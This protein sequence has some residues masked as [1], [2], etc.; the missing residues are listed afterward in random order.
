MRRA[1]PALFLLLT[2]FSSCWATTRE[3]LPNGLR[4]LILPSSSTEVMAATMLFALPV[5]M[6]G[7]EQQGLRALTHRLLL[8]GTSRETG[9]EMGSRL[10]AVGG[11]VDVTCAL[12]YEEI[13]VQAPSE[14]FG[15]AL[16]LL[17]EAVQEPAFAPKEVER[18]KARLR[19]DL[20][21]TRE[22]PFQC[23]YQA[24]REELYGDAG[25]GRW[26]LG[27]ASCLSRLTPGDV[28]AFY[29]AH[30]GPKTAVLAIAGGVEA[31]TALKAVQQRFGTWSGPAETKAPAPAE[32]APL[33]TSD[34]TVRTLP[35]TRTY[36]LFGFPAPAASAPR[37]YAMQVIDSLLSGGSTARLP[38]AL[39]EEAGLVYEV[40]SFYPTLIGESHFGV[41]AVTDDSC[42][43]DVKKGVL[44]QLERLRKEP[45]SEQELAKA[46]RS[47]LGLYALSQQESHAQAY[48]AAWYELL[49]CPPDFTAQYQEKVNTV[50]AREVQETAQ[51]LMHHF[52]LALTAPSV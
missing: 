33:A 24:L 12:D 29:R 20:A 23:T 8:R 52:I 40:S 22:D 4:V 35:T 18:E 27:E 3:V 26:A 2:T 41:F 6:D 48:S 16:E 39:R 46:K 15:V 1:L 17:A 9:D 14:G 19:T 34:L 5:S 21:A 32:E 43:G 36:L 42:I 38:K 28:Q 47:L 31:A 44:E 25:Y 13:T 50:T 37:Y 30:Y 49:G 10:A 7:P 51:E 45:V 11:S